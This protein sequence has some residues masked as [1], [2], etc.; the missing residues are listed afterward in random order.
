MQRLYVAV[1]I[2]SFFMMFM[3][4]PVWGAINRPP[5][6]TAQ[7][8]NT[9][10]DTS[11]VITLSG[12]DPEGAALS[13]S[14]TTNPTKG[15]LACSVNLCTYTPAANVNGTDGF[16]FKVSDGNTNSRAVRVSITISAVNDPPTAT[17][18]SYTFNEDNSI[19]VKPQRSD[20]DGDAT[21]LTLASA[22]TMG[23]ATLS[24]DAVTYTPFANANGS[25][26]FTFSA[27]DGK[28]SS[29][30]ATISLTINP[31]N[32]VP[33]VINTDLMTDEDVPLEMTVDTLGASDIDGDAM[34]LV[35]SSP[36]YYGT[37]TGSG[38]ATL[39][40]SPGANYNGSES[41]T[42]RAMDNSGAYSATATVTITI[43]PVSDASETT[44]EV[45][46]DCGACDD[47][48]H[49][50]CSGMY[51]EDWESWAI[52]NGYT[53]ASWKY[54]I[55]DCLRDHEIS[56]ACQDSIDRRQVINDAVNRYCKYDRQY[57]CEGIEPLPGS[58]QAEI[59]CLLEHYDELDL[60]C[61]QAL[62]D[63]Q[64]NECSNEGVLQ[65]L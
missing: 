30:P 57:Y 8:V 49:N 35:V 22:P 40:Y 36:S 1:W 41:I 18:A 4:D 53:T 32:D 23:T 14:I 21:T 43:N 62:D 48:A 7:S 55:L 29:A 52:A 12:T 65:V 2:F 64:N 60:D 39:I 50:Y 3:T 34:T 5:T 58:V 59:T 63:H 47:D 10:E 19:V 11:K 20:V 54:G 15:S 9:N 42:Y 38:T 45:V 17:G 28:V 51:S 37:V 56:Q 6:A 27:S 16:Y 25:D 24:G 46:D 31:V 13:Y 26:S 44:G 33:T 61:A